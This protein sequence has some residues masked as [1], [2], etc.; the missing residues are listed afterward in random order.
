MPIWLAKSHIFQPPPDHETRR[1]VR[2]YRLRG[3]WFAHDRRKRH[4]WLEQLR[5][6]QD[7]QEKALQENFACGNSFFREKYLPK[8]PA[9]TRPEVR[10]RPK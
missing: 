10:Y 8:S 6:A 2:P 9:S 3:V 4:Q 1:T 7:H 5:S